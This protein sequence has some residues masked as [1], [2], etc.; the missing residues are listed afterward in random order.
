MSIQ[1]LVKSVP[2][3]RKIEI[4][5]PSLSKEELKLVVEFLYNGEIICDDKS[6]ACKVFSNLVQLFGFVECME[7]NGKP[8]K[9]LPIEKFNELK[10][11]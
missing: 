2:C 11:R 10:V 3:C 5:V 8:I 7:M 4:F 9:V 1:G 6:I